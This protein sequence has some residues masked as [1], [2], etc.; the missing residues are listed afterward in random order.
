MSTRDH[1]RYV[2][3]PMNPN[4]KLWLRAKVRSTNSMQEVFRSIYKHNNSNTANNKTNNKTVF[5]NY[6]IIMVTGFSPSYNPDQD[7]Q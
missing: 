1:F 7:H 4:T 5:N 2:M 6:I 3:Q